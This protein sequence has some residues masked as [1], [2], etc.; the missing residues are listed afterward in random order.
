MTNMNRVERA[1]IDRD[2]HSPSLTASDHE[3]EK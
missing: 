2:G 3:S 1:R